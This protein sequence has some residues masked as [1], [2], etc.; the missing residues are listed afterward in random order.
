MTVREDGFYLVDQVRRLAA[1]RPVGNPWK[2]NEI[3]AA[4]DRAS[5]YSGDH[6]RF[7]LAFLEG[8]R[9]ILSDDED[10]VLTR[11]MRQAVASEARSLTD[12]EKDRDHLSHVTQVFL[13]G[14]FILNSCAKFRTLENWCPYGWERSDRFERLNRGWIFTSLLH[15][16]AYSAQN[17]FQGRN[18]E[19]RLRAMFGDLYRPGDAGGYDR[20]RARVL[21]KRVAARRATIID[22]PVNRMVEETI[23]AQLAHDS[24][25]D[26]AF[27]TAQALLAEAARHPPFTK[28]LL[29]VGAVSLWTHNFRHLLKP[30]QEPSEEKVAWFAV[31]FWD[32][33]LAALVTVSDEIQEWGRE[34]NDNAMSREMG[35]RSFPS[36]RSV[37]TDLAVDDADGLRIQAH[38]V[39]HLFPEDRGNLLR[40][41]RT[42]EVDAAQASR[43]YKNGFKPRMTAHTTFHPRLRFTDSV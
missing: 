43:T 2:A 7:Y 28:E 5:P 23:D 17:A 37:L 10:A 11:F 40:H 30:A 24:G 22:R 20:A 27:F 15:D 19:T 32:E 38:V 12:S 42:R 39:H 41:A 21:A 4:I 33:P 8:I 9:E 14:W 31:D 18:H 36:A 29:E 13:V 16:C 3:V 26:H 1:D 6:E 34:R 35:D 25:P